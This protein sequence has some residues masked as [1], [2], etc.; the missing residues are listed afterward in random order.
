MFTEGGALSGS[1]GPKFL[2]IPLPFLTLPEQFT[3]CDTLIDLV[4]VEIASRMTPENVVE[5]MFC[6][7]P[8]CILSP[9]V[10]TMLL[11]NEPAQLALSLE[12]WISSGRIATM[13]T[14]TPSCRR[15]LR[16]LPLGGVHQILLFSGHVLKVFFNKFDW[17]EWLFNGC[18]FGQMYPV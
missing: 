6:N 10:L 18:H 4:A 2:H 7:P 16:R 5:E 17:L 11:T 13:I 8:P 12:E 9:F 14:S 1:Q 3:T 15:Y